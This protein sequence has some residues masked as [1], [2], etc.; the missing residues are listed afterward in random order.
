[1]DGRYLTARY[2]DTDIVKVAYLEIILDAA[3]LR[4]FV[5]QSR[6]NQ[7]ARQFDL[8]FAVRSRE[9]GW[10]VETPAGTYPFRD[11]MRLYRSRGG[12]HEYT[13]YPTRTEPES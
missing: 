1:M 10:V 5:T 12:Q 4:N 13:T 11:G 8:S 2:R 6:I 9:D 3:G 7:V